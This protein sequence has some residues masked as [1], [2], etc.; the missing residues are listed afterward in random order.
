MRSRARGV[1][2]AL[3]V[4][5]LLGACTVFGVRGGTE[6][7]AYEVERTL[8]GGVE[9]RRYGPRLAAETAV[10]AAPGARNDAFRRLADYI[11]GGNRGERKIAMTTP[12][13]TAAAPPA[14]QGETAPAPVASAAAGGDLIMQFFL[15]ATIDPADAPAPRHPDVRL[16]EL[17]PETLAVRRFSGRPSDA[18]VID[19]TDALLAALARAGIA[20]TGRPRAFFYDPPWTLPPLRRNEVAAPV[21]GP[22]GRADDG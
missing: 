3:V 11:F 22:S 16:V 20:P 18:R 15:P 8:A 4:V 1:A 2:A 7:P 14:D 6:T 12:V 17:P 21:A 19:Q 5:L 13:A 9:I 10:A